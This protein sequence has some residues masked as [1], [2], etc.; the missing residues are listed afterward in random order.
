MIVSVDPGQS[1]VLG[2]RFRMYQRIRLHVPW[3]VFFA[4]CFCSVWAVILIILQELFRF[5]PAIFHIHSKIGEH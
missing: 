1:E 2:I 3:R 4:G 5:N